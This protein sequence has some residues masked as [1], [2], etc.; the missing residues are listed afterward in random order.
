MPSSRRVPPKRVNIAVVGGHNVGKTSLVHRICYCKMPP[1][2]KQPPNWHHC[3]NY[4]SSC[5]IRDTFNQSEGFIPQ[6]DRRQSLC[7]AHAVILVYAADCL[8]SFHRLPT[9]IDEIECLKDS[10]HIMNPPVIVVV[11]NKIDLVPDGSEALTIGSQYAKNMGFKH[12]NV[13]AKS[14]YYVERIF[15][16]CYYASLNPDMVDTR[17][18]QTQTHPFVHANNTDTCCIIL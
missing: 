7:D 11:A 8:T 17:N 6:K 14:N 4:R 15:D 5:Q 9:F 1:V 2:I 16:H 3:L 12:F 18:I 10:R 13:S